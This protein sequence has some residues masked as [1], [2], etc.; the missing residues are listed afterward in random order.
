MSVKN[1]NVET[2]VSG[3]FFE[4]VLPFT[5]FFPFAGTASLVLILLG[6]VFYVFKGGFELGI[7]FKGGIKIECAIKGENINI[8]QIRELFSSS[9][10]TAEVNYVGKPELNNYLITLAVEENA[11]EK[12]VEKALSLLSGKFG[13]EN[14]EIK[15]R[16]LVEPKIGKTF[17]Y[18]AIQL[19]MIVSLLLL[20]YI[21]FRFDI[22]Y[23]IGAIVALFHDAL[24][25][26][27][28]A[29][30][31]RIPIDITVIAAIL[32][33]LGY[34]VNDTIVVFDRMRELKTLTPQEDFGLIID[35][36][37]TQI[38]SRT[39]ITSLTTIFTSLTLYLFGGIVLKNFAFLLTVG[40]ISGTYSSIF[41][42]AYVT[43]LLRKMFLKEA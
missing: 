29:V 24:V 32:T 25:M 26:L 43:H 7:D 1:K 13:A 10:M 28:F 17:G 3:I 9:G 30:F 4:K 21:L 23:S 22:F 11:T 14:V 36:A 19:L 15:G 8:K 34:S 35:K 16:E 20:L 12:T 6:V 39:I 42:A 18:K 33:V 37:V 2:Q 40:F 41:I 27:A 31:L 5:R 38:L